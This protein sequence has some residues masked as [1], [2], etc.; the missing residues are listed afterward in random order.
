MTRMILLNPGPV[1]LSER[2]RSALSK[3]DL[4][5]REPEFAQLQTS[6]R[7]QLLAVYGLDE[8]LWAPA[9]L[10]GSGTL[11]VEA[12]LTSCVPRGERLLV[13]VN[14]VYGERI[15]EIAGRHGIDLVK[16]VGEWQAGPDLDAVAALLDANADIRLVAVVHHETTTGRLNDLDG[17]AATCKARGVELLIDA[18]SSFG[19]EAIEFERWP[20]LACAAGANKCLH[21]VPGAAFVIVK[22]NDL[23]A[24]AARSLYLDLQAYLTAQDAGGTP[25]TQSVHVQY[26]LDAALGEFVDEGG[27]RARRECYRKRFSRV[28]A[29]L[30]QH[31]VQDLIPAADSSCVLNAFHLP[32]GMAYATLHA[33]LK[34]RGFVI[35]AGQG[36]LAEGIFRLSLMGDIQEPDMTRLECALAEA[37]APVA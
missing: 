8:R 35:Y 9:L 16:A 11:A 13:V 18:V 36:R 19:A 17:L 23:P 12:M 22:R 15:A 27:W 6:I 1:T 10:T 3:P 2:V 14:G 28:R 30:A 37:L 24:G 20:V 31:G 34:A 29:V 4:C 7:R 32:H 21:G 25:F 26:A 5:H 33:A